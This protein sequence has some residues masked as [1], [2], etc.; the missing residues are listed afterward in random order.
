MKT[1]SRASV[2]EQ[3]YSSIFDRFNA[4][5]KYL[6]NFFEMS[7]I[8]S[9]SLNERC[10]V[11]LATAES[12]VHCHVWQLQGTLQQKLNTRCSRDVFVLQLFCVN[13]YSQTLTFSHKISPMTSMS[14]P[15]AVIFFRTRRALRDQHQDGMREICLVQQKNS[16][17]EIQMTMRE[18]KRT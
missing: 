13:M 17:A 2:T 5:T 7:I 9:F 10:G 3:H 4:L 18:T 14:S 12:D 6:H 16:T 11:Q 8:F 15:M 1:K